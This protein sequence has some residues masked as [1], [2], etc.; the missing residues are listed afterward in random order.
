MPLPLFF[1]C[2]ACDTSSPS[3]ATKIEATLLYPRPLLKCKIFVV[4]SP[5]F[6]I[7]ACALAAAKKLKFRRSMYY[8]TLPSNIHHTPHKCLPSDSPPPP[9]TSTNGS[10]APGFDQFL[11]VY[12]S[13][14]DSMSSV[15]SSHCSVRHSMNCQVRKE[16][17]F[18]LCNPRWSAVICY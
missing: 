15:W 14:F 8:V 17:M 13:V 4:F 11:M 12:D 1:A 2:V 16:S 6:R 7:F 9:A 18:L 10:A 5:R 3:K